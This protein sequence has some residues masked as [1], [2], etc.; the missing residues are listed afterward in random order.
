MTKIIIMHFVNNN[1][2]WG[3][4]STNTAT[5]HVVAS[6]VKTH[7]NYLTKNYLHYPAVS[8]NYNEM[9]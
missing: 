1:N 9:A 7:E 4:I 5:L 6:L 2:S 3:S 8:I